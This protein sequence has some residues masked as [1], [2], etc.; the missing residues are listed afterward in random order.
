M[1]T[2]VHLAWL[3]AA[4]L[5]LAPFGAAHAQERLPGSARSI[6]DAVASSRAVVIAELTELGE[7]SPE[8]PGQT[9][10]R[11]ARARTVQRLTGRVAAPLVFDFFVQAS[12]DSIAEVAPVVGRQ[13]VF[14]LGRGDA[15][16]VRAMRI[17]ELT[18]ANRAAVERAIAHRASSTRELR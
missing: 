12:P 2:C 1:R 6:E 9:L 18:D 4:A 16:H 5:A 13:Y 17:V 7:P 8:A 15:G 11:D 3:A 10:H 14:I